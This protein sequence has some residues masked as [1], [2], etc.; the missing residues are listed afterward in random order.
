MNVNSNNASVKTYSFRNRIF[1]M[2][3]LILISALVIIL[4][5]SS[6]FTS[7]LR[8]KTYNNIKDTLELYNHHLTQNLDDLDVFLIDMYSYSYDIPY[9][10]STSNVNRFYNHIMRVKSLLDYSLPSFTEIDGMFLYAPA[11]DTFIQSSKSL[12]KIPDSRNNAVVAD[13]LKNYLRQANSEDTLHEINLNTWSSRE[14]DSSYYLIRIIKI[15]NTYLGA[16]SSVALLTSTFENISELE[17]HVVYVDSE[18]IPLTEGD[19]KNYI[20]PIGS[21]LENYEILKMKDGSSSLLVSNEIDYCDYYLSALIPLKS[22]DVQLKGIYQIFLFMGIAILFLTVILL[23]S[24]S[25]F[26]SKPIRLLEAA[27][28]SLRKGNF[29]QK[30]PTDSSNCREILEIDTAFNNMVDEIHNLRI[31]VYEEKIAKS[32]IELQYLKSQIAPHFLINCLYSIS[33]LAG[34]STENQD[35]LQKMVQTLSDHLRYTL[36]NR[37]TVPLKEE[38]SYIKNYIELTKLRFPGYLDYECFIA[39]DC[40]DASVFPLILLMFTENTIKYNMVMGES[41][42]IKISAELIQREEETWVHLTH[43]DSGDGFPEDMIRNMN[44]LISQDIKVEHKGKHLGIVNIAKRLKL[45][46]GDTS[47]L[48]ISNEPD[49]GARIDIDI[50]HIPYSFSDNE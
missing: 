9:V 39:P 24:V 13:Y 4:W 29:D 19:L 44:H 22:I 2:I 18:G 50:P 26:L 10:T 15:E 20:L 49:A 36:S 16:W 25:Q 14:I 1:I 46:Y 21:S 8:E 28:A 41:L 31:N 34:N 40:D 23:F 7:V 3:G 47:R 37:T 5:I 33:T 43:I 30:L 6:Y 35:I 38:M 32:H 17:G 48:Q 27:A 45:V 11:N 12:S 42:L